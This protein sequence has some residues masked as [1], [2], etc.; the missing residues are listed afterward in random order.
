MR[1]P[2]VVASLLILGL[3]ARAPAQLMST[4]GHPVFTFGWTPYDS[5]N[6]GHGNFPGGPGFIPG[7][8]YYPGQGPGHCPWL[9][10]PGTPFDR[11]KLAAPATDILSREA[12]AESDALAAGAALIV[13]RVPAEAELWFNETPTAQTGSYRRFLSPPLPPE[14]TLTYTLRVRWQLRDVELWRVENVEVRPGAVSSVDLLT[15]DSWKGR[16]LPSSAAKMPQKST[17]P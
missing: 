15:L 9:D 10:G 5:I 11:R 16:R 7:Y 2:A 12:A 17:T 3:P 4:W 6:A 13:V 8:G 1:W 14:R